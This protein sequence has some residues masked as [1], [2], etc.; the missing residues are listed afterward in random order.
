MRRIA[1]AVPGFGISEITLIGSLPNAE[2]APLHCQLRV[3]VMTVPGVGS[4]PPVGSA[5]TTPVCALS[6]FADPLAFEPVT[7]TRIVRPTSAEPSAYVVP[8]APDTS[9]Q[10]APATSQR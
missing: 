3:V 7:R 10:F 2:R 1:S 4:P 6:A 8:V 9:A 5:A